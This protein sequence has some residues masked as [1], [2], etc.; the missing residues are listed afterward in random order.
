MISIF[1]SRAVE[2]KRVFFFTDC[3][4]KLASETTRTV[5]IFWQL[6]IILDVCGANGTCQGKWKT[7]ELNLPVHGYFRKD[8]FLSLLVFFMHTLS[9]EQTGPWIHVSS[10]GQQVQQQIVPSALAPPRYQ[11]PSHTTASGFPL[12]SPHQ[13]L[14]TPNDYRAGGT[15]HDFFIEQPWFKACFLGDNCYS[16]ENSFCWTFIEKRS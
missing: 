6:H 2:F 9:L 4:N 5:S 7:F 12:S 11:R 8:R 10:E 1:R 16:G 3:W 13:V 15:L 14:T